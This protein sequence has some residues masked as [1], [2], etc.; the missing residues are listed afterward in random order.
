MDCVLLPVSRWSHPS[1]VFATGWPLLDRHVTAGG[2]HRAG[3]IYDAWGVLYVLLLESVSGGPCDWV[4]VRD[5]CAGVGVGVGV[6]VC[7]CF[8]SDPPCFL[9]PFCLACSH[10]L[11][12]HICCSTWRHSA[13][14]CRVV[15]CRDKMGVSLFP[16]EQQEYFNMLHD[17]K[18]GGRR[19]L[20]LLGGDMHF[21]M[22]STISKCVVC[23]WGQRSRVSALSR[24]CQPVVWSPN[25]VCWL[26]MFF[27]VQGQGGG[28]QSADRVRPQ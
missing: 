4:G 28:V 3:C 5:A 11:L 26:W 22:R 24:H 23:R 10:P 9:P 21:A 19:A 17:W 12:I 6:C 16:D 15:S 18:R 14:W 1:A 27:V 7:V 8:P 2:T 13:I 25:V 20:T